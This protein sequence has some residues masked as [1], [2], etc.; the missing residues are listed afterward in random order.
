VKSAKGRA[1][2]W[3]AHCH[4]CGAEN[5]QANA[6]GWAAIHAGTHGHSVSVEIL[7]VYG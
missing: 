2:Q 6:Q 4:D 7:I 5:M 3:H 1:I